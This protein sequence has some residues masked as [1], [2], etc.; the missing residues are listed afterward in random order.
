MLA[1]ISFLLMLS[2]VAPFVD[3]APVPVPLRVGVAGDIA[4][5]ARLG[6]ARATARLLRGKDLVLTAGDNAY[7]DGSAWEFAHAYDPT[8]GDVLRRT[9]PSPG[10][11]DYH[12]PGAAAYFDYFGARA[13]TPGRGYYTFVRRGWRFVALN[14]EIPIGAGS[15]QLRWLRRILTSSSESCTLAYWHRPRLS[16]GLHGDDASV[17]AA[18]RALYEHRVELVVNGHDHQYQRWYPLD[19]RLGRA[20]DGVQEFVVGTGGTQLY[21]FARRD[22]RVANRAARFGIL[23]LALRPTSYRWRFRDTRGVV[24]DAGSRACV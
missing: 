21:P 4:D 16:I 1:T 14:S 9:R 18:F 5:P 15:R 23:E 10:N 17:D 24:R 2:L 6:P 11:H 3:A 8:W 7:D 19:D 13:G 20:S 12:Q 22:P